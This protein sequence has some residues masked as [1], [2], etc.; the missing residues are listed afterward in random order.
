MAPD[1]GLGP[2]QRPL[3]E[4]C[5]VNSE[6]ADSGRRDHGNLSVRTGKGGGYW[7][8]LY[9]RTCRA[10]F[11]ERK[12]TALFGTKRR[13]EKILAVAEHLKEGCGIRKTSRRP[14]WT[15]SG[16][17]WARSRRT[18]TPRTQRTTARATSG[19]TRRS[20]STAAWS[21]RWSSASETARRFKRPS[22]TSPSAPEAPPPALI[23]TDDC[24]TYPA[25]LLEEDGEAVVPPRA[26]RPGRPRKPLKRWPEG[27]A[28]ATVNKAYRNG[29]VAEVKRK[30][31]HGTQADLAQALQESSASDTINTSFVERQNGSDRGQN[32]RKRRKTLEFSKDLAL[33]IAVG[34]WVVFC[35]NFHHLH[36]GL[37]LQLSDD[38]FLHR[39]PAM[40]LGIAEQPLSV[41]EIL[42][43]Q[44]VG[45][46][47]SF[48]ATPADFRPRHA[49]G[50]A[51]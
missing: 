50:P 8:I 20:T 12:G 24:N 44:I 9:C 41:A 5:C 32:A 27:S 39:T 21:C 38:S 26:G 37:M 11:S 48:P 16:H 7:R 30:L 45:F 25:V 46:R 51:P 18:A 49:A 1:E 10:E 40:A 4:L 14:S 15:R 6:C 36:R 42:S 47:P 23:T 35:Y 28:Y 34:L 43:T 31:V 17:S 29:R 2:L 22:A 33:H 13:P 3:A 19:I